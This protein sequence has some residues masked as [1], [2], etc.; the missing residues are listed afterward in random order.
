MVWEIALVI[1][2]LSLTVLVFLL[3]PTIIQLKQFLKNVN[4]TL[5]VVNK[6]LPEVMSSVS[7]IAKSLSAASVKVESAVS[8]LAE[9]E[10]LVVKEIKVPLQH[11]AQAISIL[12]QLANKLFARKGK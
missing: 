3:I 8:D 11:I 12:L 1:L 9:I 7:E 5:D 10:E 4:G 6:D 2:L